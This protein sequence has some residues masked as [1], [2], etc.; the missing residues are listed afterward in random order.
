[1]QKHLFKLGGPQAT[2][3][4]CSTDADMLVQRAKAKARLS[5]HVYGCHKPF[6]AKTI[7]KTHLQIHKGKARWESRPCI[8]GCGPGTVYT[9]E[10]QLQKHINIAHSGYQPT[11]RRYPA[12]SQR[13]VDIR[14]ASQRNS[15][16][17]RS[18]LKDISR[19][20][21]NYEGISKSSTQWACETKN[22][23]PLDKPQDHRRNLT[24]RRIA[25]CMP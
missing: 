2:S 21:T 5:Y 13:A 16:E 17:Q 14:V 11:C 4:T 25:L 22:Y 19:K 20:Y 7:L 9:S 12:I 3:P 24:R 18:L 6:T 15:S 23:P 10:R 1:M 8:Y